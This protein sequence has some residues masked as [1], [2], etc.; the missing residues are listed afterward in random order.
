MNSLQAFLSG[1]V[2]TLFI[3]A[4]LHFLRFWRST[5]DELFLSFAGAFLLFGIN[6]ALTGLY[7]GNVDTDIGYY[8]LRL[9]GFIIIIVAIVRKNTAR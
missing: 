4:A 5:R 6:Q 7:G 8:S 2:A 1:A 9:L 3:I